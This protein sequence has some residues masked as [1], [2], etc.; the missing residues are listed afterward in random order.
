VARAPAPEASPVR[1]SKSSLQLIHRRVG[2]DWSGVTP[3]AHH[4]DAVLQHQFL[5]HRVF[6]QPWYFPCWHF[7]KCVCHTVKRMRQSW[8]VTT[9]PLRPCSLTRNVLLKPSIRV[10]CAPHVIIRTVVLVSGELQHVDVRYFRS[11]IAL[12]LRSTACCSGWLGT[13]AWPG[14]VGISLSHHALTSPP[15]ARV[16]RWQRAADGCNVGSGAWGG[17]GGISLACSQIH[18]LD[19]HDPCLWCAGVRCQTHEDTSVG[20]GGSVYD[21]AARAVCKFVSQSMQLYHSANGD[22]R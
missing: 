17:A 6:F 15:T 8:F 21:L 14:A 19:R 4:I 11:S 13:C 18:R 20:A 9:G 5:G 10:G 3:T 2:E 12:P 22:E 7:Y 1:V 16:R